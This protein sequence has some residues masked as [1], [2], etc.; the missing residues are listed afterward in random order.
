MVEKLGVDR[1]LQTSD[2][3]SETVLLG[4]S[5]RLTRQDCS[6]SESTDLYS[7]GWAGFDHRH[8]VE[9]QIPVPFRNFRSTRGAA[10]RFVSNLQYF[11][12]SDCRQVSIFCRMLDHRHRRMFPAAAQSFEEHHLL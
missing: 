9:R 6:S 11:F 3:L 1:R 8:V 12:K 5:L 4:G 7:P 10:R 2:T